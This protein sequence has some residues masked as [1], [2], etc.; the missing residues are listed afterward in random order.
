[1]IWATITILSILGFLELFF[2]ELGAGIGHAD[3]LS[4]IRTDI[5]ADDSLVI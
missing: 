5:Q 2:H 4:G 3:G 1:V